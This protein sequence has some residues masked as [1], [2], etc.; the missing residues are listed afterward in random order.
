MFLFAFSEELQLLLMLIRS[1][2][3]QHSAVSGDPN[4]AKMVL[5][6]RGA[7]AYSN[8]LRDTSLR[9][10]PKLLLKKDSGVAEIRQE[11]NVAEHYIKENFDIK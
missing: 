8:N 4:R 7:S 1:G 5:C 11:K 6:Q 9:K 2:D 3:P 10:K